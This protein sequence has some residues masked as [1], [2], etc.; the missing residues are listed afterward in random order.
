M[1]PDN[2]SG[3]H[4]YTTSPHGVSDKV[5]DY[6]DRD[7]NAIA[8]LS[9]QLLNYRARSSAI[10]DS[11]PVTVRSGSGSVVGNGQIPPTPM[12]PFAPRSTSGTNGYFTDSS[13]S[14]P[15][16]SR[17][18]ATGGASAN[19]T[20]TSLMADILDAPVS[21]NV[22]YDVESGKWVDAHWN[23]CS[24]GVAYKARWGYERYLAAKAAGEAQSG[25]SDQAS[26][27]WIDFDTLV[28]ECRDRR[29]ALGKRLGRGNKMSDGTELQE[30]GIRNVAVPG[31][32]KEAWEGRVGWWAQLE[33]R[34]L[35]G[36]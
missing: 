31:P 23:A 28:Q 16:L 12:S 15:S 27:Q 30:E 32:G 3:V 14:L 18:Y 17:V 8:I 11:R 22:E 35:R 19:K 6:P 5:S 20:I 2:A 25:S 21:K 7:T 10:L 4:K 36:E 29:A 13:H 9:S 1:Q 34:A 24:V 33:A 26:R